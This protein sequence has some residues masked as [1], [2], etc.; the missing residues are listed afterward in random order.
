VPFAGIFE[1]S[2]SSVWSRERYDNHSTLAPEYDAIR[3]KLRVEEKNSFYILLPRF[4]CYFLF[5]L[6]LSPL[7]FV[8]RKGEGLFF[9]FS[10]LFPVMMRVR[11]WTADLASAR[12]STHAAPN[13]RTSCLSEEQWRLAMR[14][15][16]KEKMVY[17]F[18]SSAAT[19]RSLLGI[20]QNAAFVA[21]LGNHLSIRLQQSLNDAVTCHG[22]RVSHYYSR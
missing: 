10:L 11:S 20:I 5:G 3:D 7:S 8:W 18:L 22:R 15:L 9:L 21:P 1:C 2:L 12:S 17:L 14:A 13:R 4:L 19:G 6:H 16:I